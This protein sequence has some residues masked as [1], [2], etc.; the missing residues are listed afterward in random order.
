MLVAA[1]DGIP[2]SEF[3]RV[4]TVLQLTVLNDN[5]AIAALRPSALD[6]LPDPR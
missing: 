3:E 6:E 1:F 2:L 4:R 5:I